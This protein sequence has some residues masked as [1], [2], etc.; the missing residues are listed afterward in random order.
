V[1]WSLP[2]TSMC[3]GALANVQ[4][5]SIEADIRAAGGSTSSALP[6]GW[7]AQACALLAGGRGSRGAR[8]GG[9][10]GQPGGAAAGRAGSA[11][12]AGGDRAR[13]PRGAAR[14]RRRRRGGGAGRV[15]RAGRARYAGHQP[16]R[17]G[18]PAGA[19]EGSGAVRRKKAWVY[20]RLARVLYQ[21][22]RRQ[23]A[24]LFMFIK[25]TALYRRRGAW[26]DR[27]YA[28]RT[29]ARVWGAQCGCCLQGVLGMGLCVYP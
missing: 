7:L 3:S 9:R 10:R 13:R 20:L 4:C 16:G 8:G 28:T 21:G 1:A 17:C 23:G 5:T 25:F 12:A 11:A 18:G 29:G 26:G 19:S 15:P 22:L 2:S 24:A 6:L 14:G 27:V